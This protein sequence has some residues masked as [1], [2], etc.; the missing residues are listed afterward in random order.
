M[1][2]FATGVIVTLICIAVG[3]YIFLAGGFAPVATASH[4]LAFEKQ[5][6][7]MALT[8]KVQKEMPKSV[9]IEAN[10][11]N[12]IAGAHEYLRNC[13]VCSRGSGEGENGDRQRRISNAAGVVAWRGRHRRSA[14]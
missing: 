6:A 5:L 8:A 3:G 12:Y 13:A 9:P 2:G 10:E 7:T 1:K 14:W 4:P 11:A